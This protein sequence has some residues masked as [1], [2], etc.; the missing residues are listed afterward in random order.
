MPQRNLR[1]LLAIAVLTAFALLWP[2]RSAHA[3]KFRF[4]TDEVLNHIQ[5]IDLKGPNGE[6]LYLG[7]KTSTH[8]FLLPYRLQHEGYVLGIRGQQRYFKLS[9]DQIKKFQAQQMLPSP[10]PPYEIGAL[11]LL[12]G[13]LAWVVGGGIAV[14]AGW[15]GYKQSLA[16][17]ADGIIAEANEHARAGRLTEAIDGYTRAIKLAPRNPSAYHNRAIAYAGTGEHDKAISD[18]TTV[19]RLLPK[20]AEPFLLRA[21]ANQSK[22]D[23]DRAILDFNSAVRIE[24]HNALGYLGRSISH[25]QK[26]DWPTALA[27]CDKV[28]ELAPDA[29]AAYENRAETYEAQ[30]ATDQAAGDRVKAAELAQRLEAQRVAAGGAQGELKI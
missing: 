27:D 2:E 17:K 5:D 11:E 23:H 22:G 15:T 18:H 1:M 13:H 9:D 28:I 4:G 25:R 24:P 6:A 7:Y 21:S 29:P 3:A 16:K 30:G 14:F 20:S 19:I 10:L 12:I 8:S 26:A